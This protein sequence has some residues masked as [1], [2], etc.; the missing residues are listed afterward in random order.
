MKFLCCLL[1]M[2]LIVS[3]TLSSELKIL[4]LPEDQPGP[5]P[6]ALTCSGVS[7]YNET[8]NDIWMSTGSRA[9]KGVDIEECGFVSA[10]VVTAVVR[11]P[12]SSGYC[13]PIL[14]WKVHDT[15]LYLK[16]VENVLPSNMV[17]YQCDVYW[18]A[19]GYVC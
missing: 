16:T 12:F 10:P 14:L 15:R 2:I 5:A 7:R 3:H 1:M 18:I 13:S 8:G 17:L 4:N 6:C 9:Y 19:T 11:G